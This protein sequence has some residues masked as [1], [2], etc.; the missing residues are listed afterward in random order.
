MACRAHELTFAFIYPVKRT[1]FQRRYGPDSATPV[2][3]TCPWRN[4]ENRHGGSEDENSP[5]IFRKLI[6]EN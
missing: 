4:A 5:Y 3:I 1:S 6:K 2:G